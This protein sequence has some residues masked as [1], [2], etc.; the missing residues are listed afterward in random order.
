MTGFECYSLYISMKN[1]FREEKFDFLKYHGKARVK[2]SAYDKRP[3][4]HFFEAISKHRSDEEVRNL[5]LSNFLENKETWIGDLKYD[6]AQEI[7]L[8]W[9]SKQDSLTYRF[10]Q[11]IKMIGSYENP[12]EELFSV[13]SGNPKIF[14]LLFEGRI[15]LE[16]LV[17]L[18]ICFGIFDRM[19]PE[20]KLRDPFFWPKNYL[21]IK[22]YAPFL[23]LTKEKIC[24]FQDIVI[25]STNKLDIWDDVKEQH[26]KN[27]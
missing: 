1:H 3:D 2:K 11:D 18:N 14:N 26:N 5:L 13:R 6:D 9:K 8:K 16:T 22:K 12:M 7:Y 17:I 27:G 19:D 10:K 25:E 20:M 24:K 15:C 21:L 23:E 4:R